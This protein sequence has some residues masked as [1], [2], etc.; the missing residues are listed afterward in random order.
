MVTTDGG[1]VAWWRAWLAT[2]D[3]ARYLARRVR[4]GSHAVV[5][6][7]GRLERWLAARAP[8]NARR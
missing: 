3:G 8:F 2:P 5:R 1:L 6:E 7:G 4:V